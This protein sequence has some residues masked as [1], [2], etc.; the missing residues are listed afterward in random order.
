MLAARFHGIRDVRVAETP[1]PPIG[2][3]DVLVKTGAAA[4]CTSDL[5]AYRIGHRKLGVDYCPDEGSKR[6]PGHEFAGM[7]VLAGNGKFWI[8]LTKEGR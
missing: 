8:M 2:H 3:G 5:E 6:T 4:V 1:V 7:S